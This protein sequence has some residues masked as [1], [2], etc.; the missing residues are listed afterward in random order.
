MK[1]N[2]A[3]SGLFLALLAVAV[4]VHSR[5]FPNMPG[6]FV[7]PGVFPT[8]IA[9]GMMAGAL[10]LIARGVR[11]R[12]R[13]PW[14][15]L[16]GWTRSPRRVAHFLLIVAGVLA[17]VLLSETVGFLIVAAALMAALFSVAGVGLWVNLSCAAL[18]TGAVYY[19][20][21]KLLRVPLPRG[22]LE[23]LPF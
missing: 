7:G 8:L 19:A 5:T 16:A 21:E 22:L 15:A 3:V 11:A 20:F 14:I 17:Y 13:E 4:I 23:L 12:A 2:D 9:L 18:S 10:L 1:F 6:Q